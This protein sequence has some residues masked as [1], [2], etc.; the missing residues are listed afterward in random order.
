MRERAPFVLQ[1]ERRQDAVR[2]VAG[3]ELDPSTTP[4]LIEALRAHRGEDVVVDLGAVSFAD[5]SVV[6]ALVEERHHAALATCRLTIA[7]ARGQVRRAFDVAGVADLF[8]F[9]DD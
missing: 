1:V 8:V 2:L 4:Q 5:S 7:G 9:A 6:R 3:G